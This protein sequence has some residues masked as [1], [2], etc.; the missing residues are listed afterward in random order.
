VDRNTS[1]LYSKNYRANESYVTASS[2]STT[3]ILLKKNN[4]RK[5][6]DVQEKLCPLCRFLS[7]PAPRSARPKKTR[8]KHGLDLRQ[9]PH[10][11]EPLSWNSHWR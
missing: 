4:Q 3:K 1:N 9:G 5:Q 7:V 10:R 8:K 6:H 11:G 2:P